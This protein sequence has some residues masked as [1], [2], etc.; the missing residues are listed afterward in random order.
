[1]KTNGLVLGKECTFLAAKLKKA[2][3]DQIS[4][5]LQSDCPKQYEQ[6][7]RPIAGAGSFGDV[8]SFVMACAEA[9]LSVECTAVENPVV[10]LSA[11][12]ALAMSL[13]AHEFS[14][15]TFFP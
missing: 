4:I 14:S 8:C 13:G 15:S 1:V 12:R 7:M 9:G 10:K 5:A 6:L 11:V 3:I 2:G